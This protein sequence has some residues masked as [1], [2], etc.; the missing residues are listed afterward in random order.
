MN[1]VTQFI[2]EYGIIAM[3]FLILLEYACFPVSSEIVLPFSGAAASLWS[4]P[5]PIIIL[6]SVV[7]ALIGTNIC[8]II[9]YWGGS[10]LI[11]KIKRRFP[12]SQTGIDNSL[13]RFRKNSKFAVCFGRLIPLCRTYIAFIAGAAKQPAILFNCYSLVGITIWN[14]MLIGAGYYLHENWSIVEGYY[15]EYKFLILFCAIF[16]LV[17]YLLKKTNVLKAHN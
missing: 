9:G 4:I 14:T 11:E 15:H 13:N 7:A 12:K 17:I 10:E 2:N 6:I 16:I 5:F 8:F 3:F 1:T